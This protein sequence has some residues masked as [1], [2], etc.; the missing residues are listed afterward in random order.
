MDIIKGQDLYR[1]KKSEFA[2]TDEVI[3]LFDNIVNEI[4]SSVKQGYIHGDLSEYNI[5]LNEGFIRLA[6]IY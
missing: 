1:I 3:T 6:S 4:Q 5:R 2:N